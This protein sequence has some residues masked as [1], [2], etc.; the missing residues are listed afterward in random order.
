MIEIWETAN[1][2]TNYI[3]DAICNAAKGQPTREALNKAA[4]KIN[5]AALEISKLLKDRSLQ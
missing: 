1:Q 3:A 5:L 4:D 2:G